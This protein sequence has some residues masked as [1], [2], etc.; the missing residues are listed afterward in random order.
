MYKVALFFMKGF[1]LSL[2]IYIYKNVRAN[3]LDNE[4]FFIELSFTEINTIT[5]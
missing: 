1:G 2:A 3:I 4:L 5:I